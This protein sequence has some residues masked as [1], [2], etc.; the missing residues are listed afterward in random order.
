MSKFSNTHKIFRLPI[1]SFTNFHWGA[2]LIFVNELTNPPLL[3]HFKFVGEK[4]DSDIIP[5]G[6]YPA[7]NLL[8][9]T[10]HNI[11]RNISKYLFVVY[12]QYKG[13]SRFFLLFLVYLF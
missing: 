13:N 3:P 6:F 11:T 2:L 4:D 1:D 12:L 9:L 7:G 10:Q 5:K 8:I